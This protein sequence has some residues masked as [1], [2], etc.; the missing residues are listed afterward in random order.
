MNWLSYVILIVAVRFFETHCTHCTFYSVSQ[1]T[2][3]P[4]SLKFSEF[5]PQR[6]KILSKILH[7]YYVLKSMAN[8]KIL[9]SYL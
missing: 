5:F 4:P 6:L 1:K 8:Y 7:A 2:L 3:P 9:F